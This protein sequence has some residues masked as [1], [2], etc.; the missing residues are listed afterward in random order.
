MKSVAGIFA[1]RHDARRAADR[2]PPVGVSPDHVTVLAPGASPE[3]IAAVRTDD[4][5]QP[6]TATAMG[7]VVGGAVG[8]AGGLPIGATLLS[9]VVPGIGPVIA[10]GI[11]GAALLGA[12][13][14]AVGRSLERS[15]ADGL[16]KDEIFFYEDALRRGRSVVVALVLDE[17]AADARR[18]LAESNAE[19]IDAAREEWWV[20]L[21]AT[22][23][24]AYS[25]AEE[26]DYRRGFE[27]ALTRDFRGRSSDEA[28]TDLRG[29]YPDLA[30]A[31]AFRRGYA[32]GQAYLRQLTDADGRER[33]RKTA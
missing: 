10:S 2:L 28:A 4:A 20:G 14:A 7:A 15:L 32:D 8:A 31:P 26:A 29:R 9:L 5:E 22:S 24:A 16:P 30:E 11:V 12:G 17:H 6:G 27:T 13:G 33:L 21:R 18:V 23:A 3:E 19:S 25:P 1:S